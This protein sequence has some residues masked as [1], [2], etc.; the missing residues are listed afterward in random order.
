MAGRPDKYAGLSDREAFI[1]IQLDLQQTVRMIQQHSE[2]IAD[3]ELL[4]YV[5]LK[6]EAMT[7][8]LPD[9]T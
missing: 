4:E 6:L 2:G 8:G 9:D 1:E 7:G 3:R 5:R